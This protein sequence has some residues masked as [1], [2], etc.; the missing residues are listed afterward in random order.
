MQTPFKLIEL[1]TLSVIGF[2][3]NPPAAFNVI[4][5]QYDFS[6]SSYLEQRLRGAIWLY[7]GVISL[8][9]ILLS[10]CLNW[11]IRKHR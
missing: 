7:A 4:G 5:Q 9:L 1:L 11:L 3:L 10:L 6:D 8:G 2:V